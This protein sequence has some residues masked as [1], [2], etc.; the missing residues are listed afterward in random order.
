M[1]KQKNTVINGF[2]IEF[3]CSDAE[4]KS[5]EDKLNL[6]SL[7]NGK[8]LFITTCDSKGCEAAKLKARDYS[9]IDRAYFSNGSIE[10]E[11]ISKNPSILANNC[12]LVYH[13]PKKKF[14]YLGYKDY[15]L[16]VRIVYK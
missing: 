16:L 6:I 9:N 8:D 3:D 12:S 4:R 7:G 15:E 11:I 10:L 5:L 14:M 2:E 1:K 13:E